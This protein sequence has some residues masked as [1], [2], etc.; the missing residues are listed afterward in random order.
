MA[1]KKAFK[2]PKHP[3]ELIRWRDHNSD[4]ANWTHIKDINP[5]ALII[6]SVGF[7]IFENKEICTLALNVGAGPKDN[8]IGDGINILKECI[9]ERVRLK[10]PKKV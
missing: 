1:T 5:K 4:F 2:E 7:L 10:V 6:E 8:D 3:V 9:V